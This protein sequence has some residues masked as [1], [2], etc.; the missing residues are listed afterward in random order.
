[1]HDASGCR[2]S[3]ADI[4]DLVVWSPD[5]RPERLK[6]E[7]VRDEAVQA[8]YLREVLDVFEAEGV[9]AA[10]VY[11]FARY[12]LP[13]RNEP[14]KDLDIVSRGIVKLLDAGLQ[15]S[16]PGDIRTCPGSRRRL[17]MLSP[18]LRK[19]LKSLREP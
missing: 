10:F 6:G 17:S 2:R 4:H 19:A 14:G 16:T 18:T 8:T 13:H 1:M 7:F 3:R 11:T 5:G 15:A 12:D 9:D